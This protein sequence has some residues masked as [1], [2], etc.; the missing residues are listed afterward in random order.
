L[1]KFST[2]R[3]KRGVPENAG[4]AFPASRSRH[5]WSRRPDLSVGRLMNRPRRAVLRREPAIEARPT[6]RRRPVRKPHQPRRFGP[7]SGRSAAPAGPSGVLA[8]A[9]TADVEGGL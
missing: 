9:L 6:R 5:A 2:D 8:K 4:A 1:R 7:E 3:Q